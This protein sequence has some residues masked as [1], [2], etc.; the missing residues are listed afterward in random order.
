MWWPMAEVGGDDGMW[1]SSL[2]VRREREGVHC[3]FSLQ[4]GLFYCGVYLVHRLV[5]NYAPF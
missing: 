4:I 5:Y 1:R 2:N 3:Q